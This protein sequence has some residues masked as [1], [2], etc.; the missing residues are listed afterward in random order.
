VSLLGNDRT[1]NKLTSFCKHR[2]SELAGESGTRAESVTC[3]GD[4]RKA[5]RGFTAPAFG[6]A[7]FFQPQGT[8][9]WRKDRYY[10]MSKLCAL[11]GY[12]A[13]LAV[14]FFANQWLNI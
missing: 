10:K 9:S 11:L 4:L 12:L 13:S 14:E 5:G 8:Q 2:K 3:E 1:K 6:W 7:K